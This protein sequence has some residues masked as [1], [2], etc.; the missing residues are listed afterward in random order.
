[1]RA[2]IWFHANAYRPGASGGYWNWNDAECLLFRDVIAEF[3]DEM[4]DPACD[5][6][7]ALEPYTGTLNVA[8]P[9]D[10]HESCLDVKRCDGWYAEQGCWK[11]SPSCLELVEKLRGRGY[12][13]LPSVA[14]AEKYRARWTA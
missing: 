7:V 3:P 5:K 10:D 6:W 4:I 11:V 13:I 8:V 14:L 1:M 12:V 9:L 2:K